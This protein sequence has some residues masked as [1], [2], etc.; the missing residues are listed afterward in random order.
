MNQ[1]WNITMPDT[2]MLPSLWDIWKENF[3]DTQEFLNDFKKTGFSRERCRVLSVDQK[4]LAALYWFDCSYGGKR[5][6][7]LYAVATKKE[8]QGKGLCHRLM[9]DTHVHL[10]RLGYEGVL[11]VPGS[12]ELFGFYQSMGYEICST[13]GEITCNTDRV[14]TEVICDSAREKIQIRTVTPQEYGKLRRSYLPEGGVI[15]EKENLNFLKCQAKLYAGADFILA[16]REEENILF[17][18]E[19]LGDVSFIPEILCALGYAKGVFRIPGGTNPFAMYC[20]LGNQKQV[21][22]TYFGLAFD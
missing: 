2:F 4:V 6:A 8:Y 3:H 12:T 7:Y 17:G 20:S 5:I 10:E 18:V 22:P 19:F 14:N 16:A 21:S 11:L 15:Q 9:E 1:N 13:I